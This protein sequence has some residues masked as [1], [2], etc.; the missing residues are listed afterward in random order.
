MTKFL[1]GLM[2]C[3]ALTLSAPI[4]FAPVAVLAHDGA[5]GAGH[6]AGHTAAPVVQGALTISGAYA[7][8]TLPRAPV[9][10][11]YMTIS[12][13]GAEDRLLSVT[14]P[15]GSDVQIHEMTM[16]D[17]VMSMRQLQDGLVLPAG[18]TV[19][20]A[21]GGYHMMIMGLTEPL[22]EGQVI[23]MVLTFAQAGAVT[24]PF[25]IRKINAQPGDAPCAHGAPEEDHSAHGAAAPAAD[26]SGHGAAA[27]AADHSG[28]G[29]APAA[30]GKTEE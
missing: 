21:P 6:G 2:L 23:E 7:R 17:S 28:H 4:A 16:I 8:A 14:A 18:G 19:E 30:D 3:S 1:R 5:H 10:G 26:H 11:A 24:V 20:L 27:P 29:A 25:E 12:N 15:V 13:A 22:V 9:G